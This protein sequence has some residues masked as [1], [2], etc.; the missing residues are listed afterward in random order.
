M[1]SSVFIVEYWGETQTE[2][3]SNG[4]KFRT[5]ESQAKVNLGKLNKIILNR[6]SQLIL[7]LYCLNLPLSGI[8]PPSVFYSVHPV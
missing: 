7:L 4:G 2:R 8:P 5:I 6:V 3:I 1:L